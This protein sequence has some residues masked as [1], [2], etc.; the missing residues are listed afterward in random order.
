MR[1]YIGYNPVGLDNFEIFL[2]LIGEENMTPSLQ[3][4]R[5]IHLLF[6]FR[7]YDFVDDAETMTI[8]VHSGQIYLVHCLSF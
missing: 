6:S 5:K 8:S 1:L 2:L 7:I 3:S 4:L